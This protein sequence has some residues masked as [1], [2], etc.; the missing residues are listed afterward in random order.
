MTISDLKHK[1]IIQYFPAFKYTL[2]PISQEIK[3]DKIIKWKLS[4]ELNL[5][6]LS[7]FRSIHGYSKIVVTMCQPALLDIS[8]ANLLC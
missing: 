1:K 6:P 4:R 2:N 5:Q 7:F 3:I 8:I